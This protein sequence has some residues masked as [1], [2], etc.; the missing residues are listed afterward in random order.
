MGGPILKD[1]RKRKHVRVRKKVAGSAERPRLNVYRSS[2]H[3]YAQLVDD[4]GQRTLA[5]VST[6]SKALA[7]PQKSKTDAARNVGA[8]IAKAAA[9]KG[10]KAVV[11]DR[12]GFIYHG[13]VRALAEGARKGGLKF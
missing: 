6:R 4:V 11:F 1:Q 2:R 10:I 12:G 5:A 13:R 9:E 3:I 8:L 7:E